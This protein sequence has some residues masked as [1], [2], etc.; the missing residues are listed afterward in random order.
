[1]ELTVFFFS[2]SKM[3]HVN[4]YIFS[5]VSHK[6]KIMIHQHKDRLN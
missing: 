5:L 1:M 2:I 4:L 3:I 6:M